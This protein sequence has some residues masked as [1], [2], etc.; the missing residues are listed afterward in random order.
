MKKINSSENNVEIPTYAAIYCRVSTEEQAQKG[1]SLHDQEE[2]CLTRAKELGLTVL[3]EHIFKDEWI[4][5]TTIDKRPWMVSLLSNISHWKKNRALDRIETVISTNMDRISRWNYDYMTFKRLLDANNVNFISLDQSFINNSVDDLTAQM[6]EWMFSVINE[7]FVKIT[8]K[9]TS[10]AME[11]K[12]KDWWWPWPAPFWYK[13]VNIWTEESPTRIIEV[14]EIEEPVVK[15]IFEKY[16][17]WKYSFFELAKWLNNAWYKNKIWKPFQKSTLNSIIHNVFYTWKILFKGEIYEGKHKPIIEDALYEKV[18]KLAHERDQWVF[19]QKKYFHYLLKWLVF[20]DK[21][22]NPYTAWKI[23]KKKWYEKEYY[24]PA[25]SKRYS[26]TSDIINE[27][28]FVLRWQYIEVEVLEEMVAQILKN[29]EISKEY[30][31]ELKDKAES[32][33]KNNMQMEKIQSKNLN[34]QIKSIEAKKDQIEEDYLWKRIIDAETYKKWHKKFDEE[35]KKLKK[36][37]KANLKVINRQ[38]TEFTKLLDILRNPYL[39]YMETTSPEWKRKI[40]SL[41]FDK[42]YVYNKKIQKVQYTSS[43][44]ELLDN[45]MV[46]FRTNWLP[47]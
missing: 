43:I 42:I 21:T 20:C 3:K 11:R 46:L 8:A 39:L 25:K 26:I 38:F 5:G 6:S 17:T 22:N 31:N 36:D 33:Y 4:S 12:V 16:A 29:M 32:T 28:D 30:L 19:H 37:Q 23:I 14:E 15:I 35:L 40:L 44:K 9:K 13:N 45:H 1:I 41:I 18:E 10:S 2:R 34:S 47:E 7:L 24:Y 27:N